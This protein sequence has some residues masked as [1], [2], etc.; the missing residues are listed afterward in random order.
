MRRDQNFKKN[1]HT[2]HFL[3]VFHSANGANYA[4]E[5][6]SDAEEEREALNFVSG[7]AAR[8]VAGTEVQIKGWTVRVGDG[9]I[10]EAQA[11]WIIDIATTRVLPAGATAE[12]VKVRLE[13]GFAKF[14][15][16]QFITNYKNL[17]KLPSATPSAAMMEAIAPGA[18][19]I[20]TTEVRNGRYALRTGG[21]VKFYQVSNGKGKWAGRTFVDAQASDDRYPVRNPSE[22][23]RI[24][25][26]I[27]ANPL[28]AEQL[29]GRELGRCSRCGR[30]LTD[31]TSRAYGIGP[32][33]RNK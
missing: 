12:S 8:P 4:P 7:K 17:A 16:S 30:T 15:G 18:E 32:D 24:L 1:P 29:Y 3:Q 25:A 11:K 6:R 10:S 31:E 13:Q 22:V 27:A 19:S 28:A 23:T 26:E 14:A 20:Q 21:V 33:C 9:F 2:A 5:M